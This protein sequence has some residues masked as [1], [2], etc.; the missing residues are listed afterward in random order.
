VRN[1]ARINNPIMIMNHDASIAETQPRP[2]PLTRAERKRREHSLKCQNQSNDAERQNRSVPLS[3]TERSRQ[4]REAKRK[5]RV[6]FAC[7]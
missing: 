6:D 7:T 3:N 5:N 4:H 1:N 2:I